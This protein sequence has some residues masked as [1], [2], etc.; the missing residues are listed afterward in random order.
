MHKILRVTLRQYT[1]IP[2]QSSST[3]NKIVLEAIFLRHPQALDNI[4]RVVSPQHNR[5]RQRSTVLRCA[6]L[7]MQCADL[8]VDDLVLHHVV[9][10]ATH[11]LQTLLS[12][13]RAGHMLTIWRK[14]VAV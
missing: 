8:A 9:Q 2:R 3:M 10:H 12:P 5:W 11:L 6:S 1:L 14:G 4:G 7:D 13:E